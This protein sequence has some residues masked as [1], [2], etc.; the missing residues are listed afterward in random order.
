[1]TLIWNITRWYGPHQFSENKAMEHSIHKIAGC[2]RAR[3]YNSDPTRDLD[4]LKE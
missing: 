2:E 1:M 4:L 3:N